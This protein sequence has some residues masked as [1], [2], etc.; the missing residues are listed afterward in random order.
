MYGQMRSASRSP[1]AKIIA[2][3]EGWTKSGKQAVFQEG[4]LI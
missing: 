4:Y 1:S 3:A 2:G